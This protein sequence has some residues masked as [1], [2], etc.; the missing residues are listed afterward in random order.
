MKNSKLIALLN[1]FN[2]SEWRNFAE[3]LASPYFNKNK[4]V[5]SFF[6]YLRKQNP[7]FDENKLTKAVVFS[8]IFPKEK[9]DR[10][11]LEDLI[12]G[13][14]KL[15]EKF[16]LVHHVEQN[17]ATSNLV[18]LEE[19]MERKLEKHYR[20]YHKKTSNLIDNQNN[21]QALLAQYQLAHIS[22]QHFLSQDPRKYD[23]ILHTTIEDLD[24][25]YFYN[26]LKLTCVLLDWKNILSVD[27]DIHF[28][29]PVIAHLEE[30]KEKLSPIMMIY[31]MIYNLQ[32]KTNTDEAFIR[33]K[34]LLKKYQSILPSK[35]KT[36]LYVF[37][38]NYCT[39]QIQQN[40]NVYFYV[41]QC[42]ELYLEGIQHKFIYENG[43]LTPWTF[44]NVV[45]LGFNLKKYDWTA[46]F[47]QEYHKHLEI[48]YQEDA[49]HFNMADLQYRKKNYDEA[50]GH[51]IQVQYSD[52][53]YVLGTKTILLKIYF[54]TDE[55]EALLSM[56]ASF[57][58]YLKRNKKIAQNIK[59]TYLNFTNYLYKIIRAKRVKLLA[60]IE[61]IK[62]VQPMTNR[63]WLLEKVENKL[64]LQKN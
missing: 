11:I 44:K 27:V 58:I 33:L 30:K 63:R 23:P 60:I 18:I 7:I 4:K 56:I 46:N 49:F 61:E 34:Q 12:Y 51:L 39:L 32:T 36:D 43:Y 20:T 8:K 1:T 45:K 16:L 48:V 3:F 47:I 54:E 59:H 24:E 28:I 14:L 9:F 6:Q 50:L 19:L 38:I 10:K 55:E 15:A 5:I 35:E 41:E 21:Q 42:L 64:N 31:L 29:E 53:F 37:G 26:K 25:F 13:L 40:N 62:R 2:Q 17:P 52:I 22:R 57:T